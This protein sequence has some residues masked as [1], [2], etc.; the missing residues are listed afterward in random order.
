M[1]AF[2]LVLKTRTV[3]IMSNHHMIHICKDKGELSDNGGL[4]GHVLCCVA[5]V[6]GTFAVAVTCFCSFFRF[7]CCCGCLTEAI[8]VGV[9]VASAVAVAVATHAGG[10]SNCSPFCD[11]AV[12][13]SCV[14][15]QCFE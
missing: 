4:D 13:E 6:A 9:A 15:E 11:W 3:A 5:D 2:M 8:S 14:G 12:L 1:L 7:C 10:E